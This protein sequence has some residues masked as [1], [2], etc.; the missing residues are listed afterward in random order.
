MG[1]TKT[2]S[3]ADIS[4]YVNGRLFPPVSEIT[5][6]ANT[7]RHAIQGIDKAE[8]QELVP[9]NTTITGTME[10]IRTKRSGGIE[11]AGLMASVTKILQEKYFSLLL[12]DRSTDSV[13]LYIEDASVDGYTGRAGAR[14]I[15]TLSVQFEGIGWENEAVY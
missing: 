2:L 11:G 1:I 14:G 5:W 12:I 8:P 7:G 6:Q 10:I 3:G 9:G 15:V 13:L 4:V